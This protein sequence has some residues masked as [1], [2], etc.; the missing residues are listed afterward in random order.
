VTQLPAGPGGRAQSVGGFQLA[1]SRYSAHS[2]EAAKLVEYLTS[3]K[4]QKLR[5]VQEGYLPTVSQLYSDTDVLVAVP[6][7]K[8]FRNAR[9][10]SWVARPSSIA[11]AKYSTLSRDYYDTV[12]RI[13]T[14]QASPERALDELEKRLVGLRI[15]AR[16]GDR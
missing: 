12:H 16:S 5:V 7:A 2:R 4:V 6:E 13:L 8:V 15:N 14:G 10:E 9:R 3:N 11:A 1:V